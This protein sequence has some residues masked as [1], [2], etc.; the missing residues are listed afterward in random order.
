MTDARAGLDRFARMLE[1]KPKWFILIGIGKGQEIPLVREMWP[2]CKLVCCDPLPYH[3]KKARDAGLVA[4]GELHQ[5]AIWSHTG[6]LEMHCGYEFD[7]RASAYSIIGGMPD[8][9]MLQCQCETLDFLEQRTGPWEDTLLWIDAEGSEYEIIKSSNVLTTG[10]VRWINC[11]LSWLNARQTPPY[12]KLDEAL[13]GKGFFQWGVHGVVRNGRQCDAIYV[14]KEDWQQKR[15]EVAG[16]SIE[17]KLERRK[18][19]GRR[20]RWRAA[21]KA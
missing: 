17:D 3:C 16:R 5:L 8:E 18:R 13:R 14:R 20:R 21:A 6:I 1:P 4:N 15:I 11:E 9:I 10:K 2:E 7:A 12:W 19:F